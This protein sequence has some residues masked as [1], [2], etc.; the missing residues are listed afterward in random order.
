MSLLYTDL[1][2]KLVTYFHD[3]TR[4]TVTWSFIKIRRVQ[5]GNIHCS[6]SPGTKRSEILRN[7]EPRQVSASYAVNDVKTRVKSLSLLR[8]RIYLGAER[9]EHWNDVSRCCTSIIA[10]LSFC[11]SVVAFVNI[12]IYAATR[13]VLVTLSHPQQDVRYLIA[14][15]VRL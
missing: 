13:R 11:T 4:F 3:V 9:G 14:R 12:V 15:L 7:V 8:K 10:L 2:W 5:I 1:K 6:Y